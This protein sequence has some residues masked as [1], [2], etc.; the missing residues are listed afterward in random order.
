MPKFP[1]FAKRLNKITGS[2]FEKYAPKMAAQGDKLVKLHIGDTYLPPQYPVPIDSSVREEFPHFN[3]YCNTFG[4]PTLR[5][6]LA[7][8]LQADNHL[9]LEAENILITNGATNALSISMMALIEPGDEV[10]ILTPAWPFFFGMVSV[11][12]G[13]VIEAPIYTQLFDDPQLEI[14]NYLEKFISTRT[15]AIY[16]N[17]P[18]N[19]SGK[20]LNH[21][22]LEQIATIAEKH[23]LWIVSDEAYDGLTFDNRPHISIASFTKMFER[24]LSIFTF[25]K[26][27]MFAGL[28]LG[29]VA[30]NKSAIKNLNKMMVHQLYSPSTLAQHMMVEPVKTRQTWL[31]DVRNHYQELRDLF[32]EN[33][34]IDL[35]KPEAAYFIFF[36]ADKYLNGRDYW[37]LIEACLDTG[38][39]VAPGDSFGKDFHN[40]IRVCFTGEARQRLEVGIERLNRVFT[41]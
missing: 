15:A 10:L 37:Q 36:P 39:S 25:S 24:T 6:A 27:F 31:P 12:G 32:V 7:E 5:E 21:E 41:C 2:V 17:T 9:H 33:L 8:K 40:Y 28:R 30:G 22:Q 29:Y 3:Q 35:W 26:S 23:D 18:N 1:D 14:S 34:K 16:V 38:V 11:A 20:V 19:P 4:I 13:Q